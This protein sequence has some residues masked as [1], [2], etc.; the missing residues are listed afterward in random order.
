[1]GRSQYRDALTVTKEQVER[2]A[3]LCSSNQFADES[4]G[5]CPG[6]FGRLCKKYGIE[7]PTQREKKRHRT[8]KQIQR[9]RREREAEAE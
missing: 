3:R 2:T 1:M 7:S 8:V 5:V 6:A 9:K 4:L